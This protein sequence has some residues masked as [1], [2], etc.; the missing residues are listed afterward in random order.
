M[1]STFPDLF[2]NTYGFDAGITGLAYLGLGKC[3]IA[4]APQ[5]A[6]RTHQDPLGIGFFLATMMGGH[7]GN[8]IYMHVCGSPMV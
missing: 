2:A 4:S 5:I 1:F 6:P 8:M 3:G 7:L